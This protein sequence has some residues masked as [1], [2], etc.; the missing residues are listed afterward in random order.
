LSLKL[1]QNRVSVLN[2][3]EI[4]VLKTGPTGHNASRSCNKQEREQ[5]TKFTEHLAIVWRLQFHTCE[6][7]GSQSVVAVTS[8]RL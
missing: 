2:E 7:Q 3:H 8:L 6:Q 1:K 5:E 4:I